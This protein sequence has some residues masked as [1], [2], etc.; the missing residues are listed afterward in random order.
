MHEGLAKSLGLPTLPGEPIRVATANGRN[1]GHGNRV[2]ILRFTLD[3]MEHVEMFLVAPLGRNQM[4]LGMP[5][6][7]R[8]NPEINWKL[9][10]V[11]YR[12]ENGAGVPENPVPAR[13]SETSV[14][15]RDS[16]TPVPAR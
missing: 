10:K 7:E 6:L 11:R 1:L 12:P 2:A 4:I 16:K 14:A 8:V 13:D 3:G 9:C 15:A 5:W